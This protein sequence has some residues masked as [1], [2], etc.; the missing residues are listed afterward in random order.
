MTTPDIK[1]LV[2]E[3]YA[4]AATR[5]SGCCGP[6]SCGCGSGP[7]TGVDMIGNAYSQVEGY[8]AEADLGLGCGLPTRHA[9]IRAGETVLDLG[10][11]A[12]IDCFVARRETGDS[13]RVIG[14]DMTPEMIAR[15]RQNAA[16]LGYGNVEF[17]LGEIE[18]LPVEAGAVDIV[19]SNCVLNLVPDKAAA[20]AEMF[21]VLKAGGRFCVSDI[22]S[23]VALPAPIRE[24]AALHVGCVAGAI[25][26]AE[27]L[28]L[29]G[30][31][32]F[33]DVRVVEAK[34]I[35]LPDDL[36]GRYLDARGLE[37]FRASGTE[38][39]SVTVLGTKA[40]SA[41]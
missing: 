34:P 30:Q 35:P 29:L 18:N 39:R 31:A 33:T 7:G 19:I 6:S 37:A 23:S 20:F 17:R 38:L 3:R 16:K 27:Y 22:V 12:G 15:A 13:G 26:E 32:G 1:T 24:A 14:V 8:V 9:A 28:A 41:A 36:L 40:A 10:S 4:D 11:G 25:V 21:R 5:A 2:R